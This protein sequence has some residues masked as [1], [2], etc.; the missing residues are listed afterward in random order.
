MDTLTSCIEAFQPTK[1]FTLFSIAIGN[2]MATEYSSC[3]EA[4]QY[5]YYS[6]FIYIVS[7]WKTDN[8]SLLAIL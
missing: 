2:Y 4:L 8:L 3:L 5:C 6:Q 1:E 7:R